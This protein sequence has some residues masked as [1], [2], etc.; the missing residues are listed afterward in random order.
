MRTRYGIAMILA[1]TAVVLALPVTTLNVGAA[2]ERP[3][4]RTQLA[5]PAQL[6]VPAAGVNAAVVP[7][8]L[9]TD[10]SL[11]VPANA[12]TTGW[13]A[14]SPRPGMTGPAVIV[15]HVHYNG[16]DGVF[17]NLASLVYGDRIVVVT[18][19]GARE[20]FRVT[21]V[22][23]FLKAHFPSELVYG[24]VSSPQLRLITCDG[25]DARGNVYNDN[26]VVFAMLVASMA[27]P[28]V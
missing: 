6:R 8:G 1:G 24:D 12:W 28:S 5:R 7:L 10:H 2:T 27:R 22:S 21:R 23:R 4:A 15:G 3:L 14:G 18:A 25:Y 17:A 19:N 9:K 11:Q 20:V 26:L 13:F 16:Q